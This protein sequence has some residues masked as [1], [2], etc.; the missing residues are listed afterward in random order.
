LLRLSALSSREN[1]GELA[2]HDPVHGPEKFVSK[3]V[4]KAAQKAGFAGYA[5]L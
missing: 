3:F 4:S 5:G 2:R 1:G